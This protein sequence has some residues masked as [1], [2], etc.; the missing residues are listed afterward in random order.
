ML[1]SPHPMRTVI[2]TGLTFFTSLL[3]VTGFHFNFVVIPHSLHQ[4]LAFII[5]GATAAS[6]FNRTASASTCAAFPFLPRALWS[7]LRLS[8]PRADTQLGPSSL[9]G[10]SQTTSGRRGARKSHPAASAD[11]RRR[12]SKRQVIF[13]LTSISEAC[14]VL[15][16]VT[17]Y[18][19]NPHV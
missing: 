3:S 1:Q 10:Q 6:R 15:R 4:F 16:P 13:Y 11:R 8:H 2:P 12:F 17:V 19:S 18:D 14:F 9:K 5:S 7:W